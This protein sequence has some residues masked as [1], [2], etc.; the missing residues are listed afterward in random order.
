MELIKIIIQYENL[1]R[2]MGVVIGPNILMV[3]KFLKHLISFGGLK[4]F[5]Y[6]TNYFKIQIYLCSSL[7]FIVKLFAKKIKCLHCIVKCFEKKKKLGL[8]MLSV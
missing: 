7:I 8:L 5:G 4:K 2:R 1:G 3:P 6:L